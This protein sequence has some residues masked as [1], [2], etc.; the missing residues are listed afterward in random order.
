MFESPRH[1]FVYG[2]LRSGARHPMHQAIAAACRFVGEGRMAGKLYNCGEYP[3]A[4][5]LPLGTDWVQGDLYAISGDQAELFRTLDSYEGCGPED[6]SPQEFRRCPCLVATPAD[7]QVSAWVYL[8][9][10]D[11]TDLSP[12][13]SGDYLSHR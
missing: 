12:I 10:W 5:A 8:Y 13:L 9:N 7:S 6:P 3:C 4:V 1:L 2:T 11:I